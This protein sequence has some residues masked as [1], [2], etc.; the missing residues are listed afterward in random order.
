[1]ES[2][3]SSVTAA[4]RPFATWQT[5]AIVDYARDAAV[6][7]DIET[8]SYCLGELSPGHRTG[9]LTAWLDIIEFGKS[10]GI[11]PVDW[12]EPLR[13]PVAL[14]RKPSVSTIFT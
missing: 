13:L 6:R 8:L 5:E 2:P 9:V 4:V 12:L 10:L 11:T 14:R 3:V 7:G 1:M